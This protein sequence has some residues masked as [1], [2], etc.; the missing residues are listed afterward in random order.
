MHIGLTMF[1]TDYSISPHIIE[2]GPSAP[3]S[4]RRRASTKASDVAAISRPSIRTHC[5]P[6]RIASSS[7]LSSNVVFPTPPGPCT[8]NTANG[9]LAAVR[10]PRNASSSAARPAKRR[11][12][13][14]RRRSAKV[15]GGPF[16]GGSSTAQR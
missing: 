14:A 9:G 5:A 12:R 10:A 7:N 8:N 6:D 3:P 2:S 11:S 15:V 4:L 1:A 13:C 16:D